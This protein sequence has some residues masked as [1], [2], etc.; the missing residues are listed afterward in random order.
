MSQDLFHWESQSTTS[1]NSPTGQRYLSG[2]S[3]VLLFAR[4]EQKDEFGTSPYVFLGPATYVSH[5]GD[6]P[7]AITW[8]LKHP[9][10]IDFFNQASA[11]SA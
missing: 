2:S 6:R 11:V 9:M 1:V 5:T 10:P 7:I 4:Q 8:K 3:T